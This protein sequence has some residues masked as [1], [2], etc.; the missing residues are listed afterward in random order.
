MTRIN[1]RLLIQAVESDLVVLDETVG[2]EILV[3]EQR[4]HQ[5]WIE[6]DRLATLCRSGEDCHHRTEVGPTLILRSD[7]SRIEVID[8]S[9]GDEVAFPEASWDAATSALRYLVTGTIEEEL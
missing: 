7:P 4:R 9:G 6:F 1:D 5:F 8:L 3:P 2:A